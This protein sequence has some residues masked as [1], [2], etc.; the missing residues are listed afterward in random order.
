MKMM[1]N[2][3]S[4]EMCR[5][6]SGRLCNMWFGDAAFSFSRFQLVASYSCSGR[7]ARVFS[8]LN[9]RQR[10]DINHT[11]QNSDPKVSFFGLYEFTA[12]KKAKRH[13]RKRVDRCISFLLRL[14]ENP[15]C[16]S[17]L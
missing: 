16:V 13:S 7:E 14:L 4:M 8:A 5:C 17:F 3:S 12:W 10:L 15:P 2:W 9:I 11:M 1:V 6:V